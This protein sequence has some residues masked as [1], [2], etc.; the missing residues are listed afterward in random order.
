MNVDMSKARFTDGNGES[1]FLDQFFIAGRK[2][3]YVHIPDDV[4]S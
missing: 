2:I 1:T 3:R 4:S